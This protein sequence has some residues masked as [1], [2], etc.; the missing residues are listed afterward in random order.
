MPRVPSGT[1]GQLLAAVR[2]LLLMTVVVGLAY[3]LAMLGVAQLAFHNHAD[4][5]LVD[6]SGHAVGSSLIG[7]SFA[8]GKKAQPDPTYFQSRPSAAGY[9][10]LAS[11]ASNLSPDNPALVKEVVRRRA[12][13]ARADHV[14][15]HRV[16]AD[17]V[18]A[19]GSG[20]DP[21]ISPAYADLQVARV[22]AARGVPATS[23]RRLVDDYTSHRT[24]GFL[25][26]PRVDVLQLNLALDRHLPDQRRAQ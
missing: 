18:T 13:V 14:P 16:P 5:S 20:L 26:E 23:V 4:G 1:A 10:A 7:Q 9:D 24:F 8:I 12:E 2:A 6:H 3:P 15:Q 21:D 11:G 17:A 22:A 19:S 25:G